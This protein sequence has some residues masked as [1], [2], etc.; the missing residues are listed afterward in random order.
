ML[1]GKLERAGQVARLA[2]ADRGGH[3]EQQWAEYLGETEAFDT[4]VTDFCERYARQNE[5]D[6]EK[7]VAAVRSGRL[8]AVEGV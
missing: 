8:E 3:S 7:F 5:R 4:S 6:Y 1:P 2:R